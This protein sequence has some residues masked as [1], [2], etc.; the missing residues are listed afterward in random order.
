MNN[1]ALLLYSSTAARRRFE[2]HPDSRIREAYSYWLQ[3]NQQRIGLTADPQSAGAAD[4]LQILADSIG[5]QLNLLAGED[6]S[7]LPVLNIDS[8]QQQLKDGD[9]LVHFI[10]Y[11]EF[12]ED[13]VYAWWYAAIVLDNT[14]ESPEMVQLT[15]EASLSALLKRK[16]GELNDKDYIDRLYTWPELEEDSLLFQGNQLFAAIWKPIMHLL[17]GK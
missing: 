7:Y 6:I 14:S 9:V 11:P 2:Q 16:S 12:R 1:R 10:R 5:K 13:T 4:S 3:L 8:V 17:E 15:G